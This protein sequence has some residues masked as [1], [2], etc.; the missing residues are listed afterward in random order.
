MLK[1]GVVGAGHFGRFHIQSI[2]QIPDF[3]LSGFFDINKERSDFIASEFGI[4][5]FPDY[6]TLLKESD[7]IDIVVP[8]VS[9]F[10][11]AKEAIRQ[12]K[13]VFV[14]KPLT[15]S[16]QEARKL[17]ELAQEAQIKA[18]TGHIERFNPA[19]MAAR[20]YINNPMFIEIHRL[21]EFTPRSTDVSVIH[22]LMIHDI[23]IVLSVV[24][25]NIKKIHASGVKVVTDS[26]DIANARLEFDNGCVANI[27]S[28]RI[29]TT[30]MRRMR[31]F[32]KNMYINADCLN[33][34]AEIIRMKDGGEIELTGITENFVTNGNFESETLEVQ[35]NNAI[36]VEL[37]EF[38]KAISGNSDVPVSFEDGYNALKVASIISEKI[39]S[40]L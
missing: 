23:D 8:T 21:A 16:L 27:T 38:Y 18:Q 10:E 19:F 36:K 31:F 24:K 35:M 1:I 22:N 29:S 28:S 30:N 5:A 3:T 9:H 12:Q 34:R 37:E 40:I 13:H 11:C 14:E 33:K 7:V 25:S 15:A 6:A 26:T 20:P 17:L 32:Q 39:E 4:R 2:L